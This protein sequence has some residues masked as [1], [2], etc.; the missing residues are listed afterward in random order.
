M[1][2]QFLFL[3]LMRALNGQQK[4]GVKTENNVFVQG[5]C[6]NVLSSSFRHLFIPSLSLWTVYQTNKIITVNTHK[7]ATEESRP[8]FTELWSAI[9]WRSNVKVPSFPQ[10]L[11][12]GNRFRHLYTQHAQLLTRISG[13]DSLALCRLMAKGGGE[14]IRHV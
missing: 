3:F 9:S 2:P 11:E 6:L 1:C 13:S 7:E 8:Y 14:R 4:S 10:P 12:R 5:Q